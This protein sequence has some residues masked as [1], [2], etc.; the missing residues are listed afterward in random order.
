M[1]Q[2]QGYIKGMDQD[3]ANSKRDPNSYFSAD[4]FR[5]VTDEGASSGSLEV[6]KGTKLA[7]KIPTISSNKGG[8]PELIIND[9]TGFNLD[10]K[11]TVF[12]V[13]KINNILNHNFDLIF[14]CPPYSNLEI[15][16]KLEGDISNM[17]YD[18]FIIAY[19]SIIKKST[20][21]LKPGGYACFVV[22]EVRDRKG[23][24][25]GFVPDTIRVMEECGLKYYNECIYLNSLSGAGLTAGRIMSISKK[26][27]KVHQNVL[28]FKKP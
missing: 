13:D 11:R 28:I 3:S 12:L 26:V 10:P 4:N 6:E 1:K 25:I 20:N 16:S 22:G 24:Y 17:N 5:V 8:L 21:H 14:S 7:F 18:D 23:N 19:K 15:Y 2:T 27:K 9:I